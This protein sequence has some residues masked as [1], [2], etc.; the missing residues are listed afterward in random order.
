MK[1]TQL[2]SFISKNLNNKKLSDTEFRDLIRTSI[3][4]LPLPEHITLEMHDGTQ[5]EIA[6][7][8]IALEAVEAALETAR[9]HQDLV[10]S[11]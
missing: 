4:G 10:D 3:E 6:G 9:K 2:L 1:S 7:S 8:A 11:F 5:E